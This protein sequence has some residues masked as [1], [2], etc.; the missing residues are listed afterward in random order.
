MSYEIE[1]APNQGQMNEVVVQTIVVQPLDNN[2][3]TAAMG[4]IAQ[5]MAMGQILHQCGQC[6]I[7]SLD[8]DILKRHIGLVHERKTPLE[9]MDC[10]AVFIEPKRLKL[11][12]VKGQEISE[13]N[14]VVINF[15]ISNEI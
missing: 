14:C 1:I 10:Y 7:Y 9:C 11:H 6:D 13:G 4:A 3:N 12:K 8:K 2:I 5:N 15:P